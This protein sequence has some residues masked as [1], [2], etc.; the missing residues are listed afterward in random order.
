MTGLGLAENGMELAFPHLG[1]NGDISKNICQVE[2]AHQQLP[3]TA[4]Y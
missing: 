4:K 2:Q 3:P 1:H